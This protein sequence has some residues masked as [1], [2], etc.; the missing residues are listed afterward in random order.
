MVF[1]IRSKW[2]DANHII[3]KRIGVDEVLITHQVNVLGYE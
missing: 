2:F 1:Q 3:Q